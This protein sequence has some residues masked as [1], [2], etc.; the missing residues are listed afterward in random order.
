M[1]RAIP[2]ILSLLLVLSVVSGCA[3]TRARHAQTPDA[4]AEVASLQSQLQ[5]KDQR[6]Q[7]L[8]SQLES[9]DRSLTTNFVSTGASDK[10]KILR[11]SGVST[12]DLQKALVKAGFDPGPTDG[13]LGKKTRTAVKAF[14]KKN[15][16]TA[17][18]VVGEKTW[19]VLR[20][21]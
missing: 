4:N 5:A 16:L 11:V 12:V 1:N 8:Q 14:Q 7:E 21:A 15:H 20:A 9:K 19:A 10:F 3:T 2:T 6:I 18:G 17:D 13:R